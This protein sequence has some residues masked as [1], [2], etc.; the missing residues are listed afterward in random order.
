MLEDEVDEDMPVKFKVVGLNVKNPLEKVI[1][2]INT[3]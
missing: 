2:Y 1:L 3:K